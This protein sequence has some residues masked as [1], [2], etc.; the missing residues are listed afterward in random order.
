VARLLQIDECGGFWDPKRAKKLYSAS[1]SYLLEEKTPHI[2]QFEAE[3][4]LYPEVKRSSD[5]VFS[6]VSAPNKLQ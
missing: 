4:V 2:R 1:I 6:F 3:V 5:Q